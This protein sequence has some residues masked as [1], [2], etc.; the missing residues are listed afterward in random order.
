MK[1]LKYQK[2]SRE[3]LLRR[4][5][6]VTLL[7]SS[8]TKNP[9]YV[10]KNAEI[11]LI[12]LPVSALIPEQFYQIEEVLRK[13]KD[14][15]KALREKH[16]DMFNLNG[17]VS[18]Y[19]TSESK[20]IH[21]LLPVVVE[22]Q[23]EKDGSVVPIIL[24]GCHRISIARSQ[25][26]KTVQVIEI[27]KVDEKYPILGYVNPHGWRDVELVKTAPEKKNKRLWRFPLKEVYKYYRDFNSAFENVG[28]PRLDGKE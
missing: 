7:H 10:Y 15:Q 14:L 20:K 9:I 24:D 11:R 18:S 5:R 25:K 8:K 17:Y 26:L 16:V 27:A 12:D 21:T 3:E 2:H 22:C 23:R 6:K 19:V 4:L 28:K 1:I 13:L